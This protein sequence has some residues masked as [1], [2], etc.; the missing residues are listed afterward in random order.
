MSNPNTAAL[1]SIF[2]LHHANIDRLWAVWRAGDERNKDPQD[3]ES[4]NGPTRRRSFAPK[5]SA[6][7][8]ENGGGSY[9]FIKQPE[10]W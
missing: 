3:L 9:P 4:Q 6:N 7:C 1:D 10:P 2:W 5:G 8:Q